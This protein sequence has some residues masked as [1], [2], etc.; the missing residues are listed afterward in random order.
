MLRK[1]RKKKKRK[2]NSSS[3]MSSGGPFR[4]F[5]LSDVSTQNSVKSSVQRGIRGAAEG[6]EEACFFVVLLSIDLSRLRS[7]PRPRPFSPKPQQRK[8]A[9]STLRSTRRAR[10]TTS[11]RRRNRGTSQSGMVFIRLEREVFFDPPR[12]LF[13]LSSSLPLVVEFSPFGL[14]TIPSRVA[15]HKKTLK[16]SKKLLTA[17]TMSRSLSSTRSRSFSAS[18]TGPGYRRCDCYTNTRT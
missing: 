14:A 17:P 6:E 8:S 16:H 12:S 5:S 9:S 2:A 3:K 1:E 15:L 7:Q 11:C 4:K 10:S 13:D 18:A